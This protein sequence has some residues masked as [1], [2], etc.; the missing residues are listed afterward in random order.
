MRGFVIPAHVIVG[1][2]YEGFYAPFTKENEEVLRRY[3]SD[4]GFQIII[5]RDMLGDL[6]SIYIFVHD[7][8]ELADKQSS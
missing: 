4:Q 3:V 6:K 8:S 5:D 2:T 7:K 1:R